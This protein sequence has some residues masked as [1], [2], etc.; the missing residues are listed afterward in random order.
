MA[1][2]SK[3]MADIKKLGPVNRMSPVKKKRYDKLMKFYQTLSKQDKNKAES[4][5]NIGRTSANDTEDKRIVGKN[6]KGEKVVKGT[7]LGNLKSNDAA[8]NVKVEK[9][10][11]RPAKKIQFSEDSEIYKKKPKKIVNSIDSEN[12][13][14]KKKIIAKPKQEQPKKKVPVKKKSRSNISNS[15]S[16]DA[17]FT[18]K[19]LEK[20]GLNPKG[21]MSEK[22][23]AAATK[24]DA[25]KT[26]KK[27]PSK[28]ITYS[29]AGS[30]IKMAKGYSAGGQ[31]F[32]GR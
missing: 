25:V 27:K 11:L 1:D 10:K 5:K 17:K 31:I 3:I 22:N 14:P 19:N 15:S 24:D 29:S 32:T 16:Y 26:V 28:S 6:D 20:R 21:R 23:Y 8:R 18:K 13:K 2:K 7:M 9:P 4:I 30:K 12:Y